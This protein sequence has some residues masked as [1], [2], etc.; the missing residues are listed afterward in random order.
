MV[1]TVVGNYGLFVAPQSLCIKEVDAFQPEI[2]F[3]NTELLWEVI[4]MEKL[5]VYLN[6]VKSVCWFIKNHIGGCL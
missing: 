4:V 6:W 1:V 3:A 2:N 5:E